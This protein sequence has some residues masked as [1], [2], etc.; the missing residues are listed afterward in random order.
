MLALCSVLLLLACGSDEIPEPIETKPNYFPDTTGSRWVY[1]H[2]DGQEWTREITEGKDTQNNNYQTFS[3]TPTNPETEIDILKPTSFR[4]NQHHILL[5][6][7]D[8]ID[9][10]IQTELPKAV[11]DNFIGLDVKIVTEQISYPDFNIST[12]TFNFK[13]PVGS[14]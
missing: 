9:R 6:V 7:S 2:A 4:V 3:Y 11:Q 5:D 12:S 10:Y 1:R 8:K 13:F 14:I